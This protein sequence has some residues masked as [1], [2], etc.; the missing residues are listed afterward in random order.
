LRFHTQE[1]LI[2]EVRDLQDTD[3]I[4]AFLTRERGHKRGVARGARRRHSRFSGQ[5]QPLAKVRVHWGEKE[6]R[7]LVR[8][9]GADLLRPAH[10]LGGDLEGLLLG[11]YLA[12]HMLRFAQEDE[13]SELYFRLLDSTLEALAAG[14]DRDLAA[15]YFEAWVLR[16]AGIFPP[17]RECP[18]CGGP[19]PSEGAVLPPAGEALICPRCAGAAAA[20][21]GGLGLAVP[22][23][24][25]AFLVAIG[26]FGLAGLAA[27]GGAEPAVL[28]CA[29]E[30]AARV[31][32]GFLGH[33]LKSY[34]VMQRTLAGLAGAG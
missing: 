20:A 5:L 27:E 28:R 15:R 4:V 14:V 33:E 26:R 8:I 13:P 18:T 2:L 29:E 11:S 34:E 21:A 10:G 30:L 19:F 7:E 22:V 23:P 9:S 17:P 24:V 1:A 32:R 3:R 16:L 12:D 25:L 31:R 6:G